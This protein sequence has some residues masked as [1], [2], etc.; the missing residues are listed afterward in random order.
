MTRGAPWNS[1]F[2]SLT[3]EPDYLLA[4]HEAGVPSAAAQ[5][6]VGERGQGARRSVH[7][8]ICMASSSPTPSSCRCRSCSDMP[9]V[10]RPIVGG[11]ILLE[12]AGASS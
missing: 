9:P 5:P 4:R 8:A 12:R 1:N 11:P 6:G 10:M 3:A 7:I 2:A